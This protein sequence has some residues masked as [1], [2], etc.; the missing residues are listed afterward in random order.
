MTI[1][2]SLIMLK[3]KQINSATFK[4][5]LGLF[6]SVLVYYINNFFY[7]LG[8]TEKLTLLIAISTPLIMLFLANIFLYQEIN[9]K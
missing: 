5:S 3:V 8:E 6:F 7:V 2:S 4:I 1:F 9:E